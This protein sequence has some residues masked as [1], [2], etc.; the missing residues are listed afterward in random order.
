[1]EASI[2]ARLLTLIV[3]HAGGPRVG[4]GSSDNPGIYDIRWTFKADRDDTQEPPELPHWVS[5]LLRH[6]A[7]DERVSRVAH[8]AVP[9]LVYH[10]LLYDGVMHG[11]NIIERTTGDE[12]GSDE[13]KEHYAQ[14][15]IQ[16]LRR[17]GL[18]FTDVY[19]PLMMGGVLVYD[20]VLSEDEKL[21]E[22][23]RDLRDI[24]EDRRDERSEENSDI[25][26]MTQRIVD[27]ALKKYG[28]FDQ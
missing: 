9:A 13:E 5:G 23:L 12:L 16:K 3:E 26:D 6:I 17:G 25:F 8:K 10:E 1:L 11:F 27:Q 4:H 15:I 14:Q 19:M 18:T 2:I 21:A 24:L 7:R 20:Q 22:V 28:M